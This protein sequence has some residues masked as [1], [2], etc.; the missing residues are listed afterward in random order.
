MVDLFI[1]ISVFVCLFVYT[2]IQTVASG[3]ENTKQMTKTN[4]MI[5]FNEVKMIKYVRW[6]FKNSWIKYSQIN[7][8]WFHT[9]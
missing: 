3:I 1:D 2:G 8:R 9:Q 6:S 5:K 4:E 7:L